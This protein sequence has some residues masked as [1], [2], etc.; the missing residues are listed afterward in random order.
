MNETEIPLIRAKGTHREVGQQI[1]SA[2]KIK[3]RETIK[4]LKTDLSPGITWNEMVRQG[5]LCLAHTQEAYPQYVEELEGVAEGA[6]LRFEDVFVAIC[7]CESIINASSGR[8]ADPFHFR[9]CTDLAARGAATSDGSVLVAHNNDNHVRSDGREELALI[10]AQAGDEPEF[11]GVTISGLG[12]S[13][14]F[15][16]AGVSITG[17]ALYPCDVRPGVPRLLQVRAMLGACRIG[18]MITACMLP[19]R[20]SSYN[21]VIADDNGEVYSMEGSATD[22]EPLYIEDDILCHT[23]HYISPAMRR[24]EADRNISSNSVFRFNRGLRLLQENHGNL[25]VE[26]F[27]TILADHVNYPEGICKHASPVTVFS[28]IIK[29][30]ERKAWI[31]KGRACQST[32]HEYRLEPWEKPKDWK[33]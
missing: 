21:N 31:A 15:N 10:Q 2:Q 33:I 19:N 4:R 28:I 16:A 20:S 30:A 14:G 27:K 6:D 7:E 1:G 5:R 29:N 13:V 24:F 32:Y 17:N 22:C 8:P 25:S 18:E 9:G 12:Y 11:I 3:L 23:N 26:M